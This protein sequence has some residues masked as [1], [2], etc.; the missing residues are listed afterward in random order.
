MC[1]SISA[2]WAAWPIPLSACCLS[3][4]TSRCSLP[5]CRW[6]VRKGCRP[7]VIADEP[8]EGLSDQHTDRIHSLLRQQTAAGKPVLVVSNDSRVVSLA[9]RRIYLNPS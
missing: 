2:G 5:G 6:S 7:F 9:D 4:P 3:L 8:T 1:P